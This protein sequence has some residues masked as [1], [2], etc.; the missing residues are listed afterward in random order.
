MLLLFL[1]TTLIH[2][3][4]QLDQSK[5]DHSHSEDDGFIYFQPLSSGAVLEHKNFQILIPDGLYYANEE[6]VPLML[7][8]TGASEIPNGVG[9]FYSNSNNWNYSA[10][11]QHFGDTSF[12]LEP[13][14][15]AESITGFFKINH[16]QKLTAFNGQADVV[17][18]PT[19]QREENSF[20]LGMQYTEEDHTLVIVKKIYATES[21]ALVITYSG[22]DQA[23]AAEPE[24]IDKILHSVSI[25]QNFKD[26]HLSQSTPMSYLQ[27]M[28]FVPQ[29]LAQESATSNP[30]EGIDPKYYFMSAAFGLTGIILLLLAFK[31]RKKEEIQAAG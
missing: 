27:L 4:P 16:L 30:E 25:N 18:P 19:Y 2:Q 17:I 29:V 31:L 21:G 1:L 7:P 5:H 20:T 15:S 8:L 23:Y 26:E 10:V 3:E 9:I 12:S 22:S 6:N 11:V 24:A 14:M 13:Q 28:G